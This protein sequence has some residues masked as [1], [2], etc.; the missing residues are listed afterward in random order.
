MVDHHDIEA[1][2]TRF[3]RAA[4]WL[5]VPQSTVTSSLAPCPASVRIA[6]NSARS[7]RTAIGDVDDAATSRNDA[8]IVRAALPTSPRHV[9]IAEDRDGLAARRP[10]LPAGWRPFACRAHPDPASASARSDRERPRPLPPG[11]RTGDD[12]GQ[13]LRDVT[14]AGRS[15]AH[16]TI[17][18]RRVGHARGGRRPS[19]RPRGRAGGWNLPAQSRRWSCQVNRSETLRYWMKPERS[20]S[21]S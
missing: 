8:D 15:R 9:V 5:V 14:S 11:R 16:A 13:Q 10:R 21:W 6:S 12:A 7:P 17:R 18:A 19:A 1:E 2:R 4:R 20:A 3:E